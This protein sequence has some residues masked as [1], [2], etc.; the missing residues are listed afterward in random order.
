[1]GKKRQMETNEINTWICN[2]HFSPEFFGNLDELSPFSHDWQW[3]ATRG[4]NL[5]EIFIWGFEGGRTVKHHNDSRN[6][7]AH[8]LCIKIN[9]CIQ[10][11][12]IIWSC[13]ISS[14]EFRVL[15]VGVGAVALSEMEYEEE[16]KRR[17][18]VAVAA[19][20]AALRA[21]LIQIF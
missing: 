4:S 6:S 7:S 11:L 9:I 18:R 5:W 1:M 16:R 17:K 3:N 13:K 8:R 15:L 12:L 10:Q 2:S 21:I 19:A 14:Y 20:A